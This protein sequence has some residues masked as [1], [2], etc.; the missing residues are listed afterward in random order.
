VTIELPDQLITNQRK[1][2]PFTQQLT[3]STEIHYRR[4]TVAWKGF[5]SV[6]ETSCFVS[7]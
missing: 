1:L 2:L 4:F 6:Q 3:G 5:L 7:K